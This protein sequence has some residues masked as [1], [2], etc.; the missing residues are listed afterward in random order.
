MSDVIER[1]LAA[2]R[3]AGTAPRRTTNGWESLC[4]AHEDRRPS[5]TIGVGATGQVLLRCHREPSCSVRAIVESVG[6]SMSDL[7]PGPGPGRRREHVSRS[8]RPTQ[9]TTHP[10]RPTRTHQTPQG[11]IADWSRIQGK[12][13]D[14][15]W[16]YFDADGTAVGVVL[17]WDD[18][19]AGKVLRP[20]SRDPRTGRWSKRAMTPLR[21]L[22][23]LPGLLRAALDTTVFV[24]EGEKAADAGAAC[25]LLTT[26]SSHGAESASRTDWS[27]LRGRPVVVLP[28]HDK[29]GELYAQAVLGLLTEAGAA[30]VTVA[31]LVDVW[32]EIPVRGDIADLIEH[33]GGDVE[34]VRRRVQLLATGCVGVNA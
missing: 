27:P 19:G 8:T 9:T 14:H 18:S 12:Q 33:L 6:L 31:R 34:G 20:I 22:Y 1:V 28:D 25:G 30:S 32:P 10:A 15:Q 29:G 3:T 2:L 5:L 24:V 7:F 4:P 11:A 21:P 26:T 17:R 13:P 16:V 23:G